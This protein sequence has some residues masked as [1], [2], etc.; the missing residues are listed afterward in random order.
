M[1]T[2]K[3]REPEIRI[4]DWQKLL[5]VALDHPIQTSLF[6]IT[7]AFLLLV[8]PPILL[9]LLLLST[10]VYFIFA[11]GEQSSRLKDASENVSALAEE[12]A[13]PQAPAVADN[14]AAPSTTT[15]E[16]PRSPARRSTRRPSEAQRSQANPQRSRQRTSRNPK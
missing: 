13:A 15:E 12:P 7:F 14:V 10:L 6:V 2:V 5:T 9:S 11:F 4:I 3:A 8:E 16:T 1:N